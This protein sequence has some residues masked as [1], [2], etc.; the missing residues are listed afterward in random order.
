MSTNFTVKI[1]VVNGDITP[2]VVIGNA[3]VGE[4]LQTLD[5]AKKAI[6]QQP[7]GE[8]ITEEKGTIHPADTEASVCKT[9]D[10]D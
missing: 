8:R 6:Y 10:E 2:P 3:T 7:Y 9:G 1:N 5:L 4:V